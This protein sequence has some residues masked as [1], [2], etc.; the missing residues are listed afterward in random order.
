MKNKLKVEMVGRKFG[1]LTVISAG[2]LTKRPNGAIDPQWICVCD[3]GSQKTA[4]GGHLR[5]GHTTSCGCLKGLRRHGLC[6]ASEYKVW[7]GMKDRCSNPNRK[8]YKYYGGRGIRVC[9]RWMDFGNF[10]ADMGSRPPERFSIERLDNDKGYEPG[11]C[12]WATR[13]EQSKNLQ[14]QARN[15]SGFVGVDR[16]NNGWTASIR[17][18]GKKVRIGHFQTVE[19]AALARRYI[20]RQNGFKTDIGVVN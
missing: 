1:A 5:S 10:I 7:Q 3:C 4:S 15:K 17:L 8:G 6:R 11:N 18:G 12:K 14:K 9:D 16:E 2:A 20:A 13:E 19:E